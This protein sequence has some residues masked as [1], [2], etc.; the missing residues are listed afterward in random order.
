MSKVLVDRELLDK[1]ASKLDGADFASY[2]WG[3]LMAAEVREVIAQPAEA[4]GVDVRLRRVIDELKAGFVVC[5]QCGDQED[6]ATLDCVPELEVIAA[7][8]SA[9]TAERDRLLEENKRLDLMVSEADFNYDQDRDRMAGLLRN[10]MIC[11]EQWN[12]KHPRLAKRGEEHSSEHTYR[13]IRAF[14]PEYRA[15]DA[16]MAAKEE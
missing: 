11:L 10:A 14:L 9:V 15:F 7:A 16:A 4:E 12:L 8:L 13:Q 5:Q 1:L 3:N 2:G 6:T